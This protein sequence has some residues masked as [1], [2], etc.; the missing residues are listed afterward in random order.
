[1]L[2]F[3]S[4]IPGL[5]HGQDEEKMTGMDETGRPR[6]GLALGG[7]AA[8]GWA[9]IGV[10]QVLEEAG[11]E[12][13]VL[14]GTSIGAVAAG[15]HA[16]GRLRELEK[17]ARGLT[18]RRLLGLLDLNLRGTSLINGQRLSDLLTQGLEGIEIEK[19]PKVFACVAT[20]IGTGHEIWLSRGPLAEALTASYALPGIFRPQ[21]INGRWLVDGTLV[22]P[23]PVSVCRAFSARL[24][25]SVNLHNSSFGR[26]TVLYQPDTLE[27]ESS[28]DTPVQP[29]AR[30]TLKKQLFTTGNRNHP[31]GISTVM[32]E[33]LNI[34]QD[35]IAR[36]RLAGD[37][38]DLSII[39]RVGHISLYD[40]HMADEA[41]ALGR[42][43]AKRMLPE[44]HHAI[45]LMTR[46]NTL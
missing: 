16:A 26:G 19:L 1:M 29:D 14:A 9:H 2:E 8:R 3:V 18:K 5:G 34:M 39:P 32:M 20:E 28:E 23:V 42:D 24:V 10:L 30:R 27:E 44:I 4:R 35:R 25:I 21:R 36:S 31:P 13:D 11:I 17:F 45:E 6:I 43:A 22:N 38:P 15:C 46:P 12:V 33:S 37:P 40:F 41:I 7:G